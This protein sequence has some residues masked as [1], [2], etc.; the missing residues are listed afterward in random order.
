MFSGYG[1]ASFA[2]KRLGIPYELVGYSDVDKF[3]NQ[4]FKQNHCSDDVD[5]RLRLG[6]VKNVDADDLEDFDLLT[7]GFPCQA[8]S[9]A[10]KMKGELDPRGTLF[11][12]II[13]IACVK[14][15][16][17]M[18]LENVKG[19]T[20]KKFKDTFNKVL[21]EL[22]R[23]GYVVHWKVLNTKDFGVPQNRER[24][25]FVC[26]RKDVAGVFPFSFNFPSKRDYGLVLKDLLEEDVD[27]KYY[28]SREKVDKLLSSDFKQEKARFQEK[29]VCDTLLSRDYKGVKCVPVLTPD[30]MNKRQ[31]GR[32]FKENDNAMFTLNTQDR[33]GILQVGVI[34]KEVLN[35][36]E[37]QRRLYSPDGVSPTVLG[38]SDS[39][40]IIQVNN[41]KHSNDRVYYSKGCSPTLNSMQGGNRQP[42]IAVKN[43]TL[44]GYQEAIK[45]DG[46]NLEQPNSKTRRWRVQSGLSPCLQ[47]NDARGVVT[48]DLSIRKL[49]PK[50]CF[51]LMGFLNDEIN[52]E[53]L[54]DTQKYK[55][56]GNGQDV[57]L[58]S[59]LFKEMGLK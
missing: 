43:A 45:G 9:N 39:S 5:D 48:D 28:L 56:A 10:G 18:L 16:K 42:F 33:H 35:D 26:F 53:G 50:E 38:R 11:Y 7:G 46:I 37:R 57:N 32:R 21:S 59:L 2:I 30:R 1:T 25:W 40:K 13:R 51:R 54:S 36:N 34:P 41:P 3:A 22:K 47:C 52:L 19:F 4:C 24:V 17:Y 55:L 29:D 44:K 6:D 49:T 14:Q 58:V 12:E 15:P 8:F 27:A 20:F 23:I 31:N